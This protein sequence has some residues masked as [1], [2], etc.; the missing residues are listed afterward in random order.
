MPSAGHEQSAEAQLAKRR[1]NDPGSDGVQLT[2]ET[3][4][5]MLP[6]IVDATGQ[7]DDEQDP[8]ETANTNS[9][10]AQR[11]TQRLAAW[12]HACGAALAEKLHGH[13]GL[14]EHDGAAEFTQDPDWE[15]HQ[16]CE[17]NTRLD[18]VTRGLVSEA[19]GD[20][21]EV[22][23][24][25]AWATRVL[26]NK[27]GLLARIEGLYA[28]K[29]GRGLYEDGVD[30][31]VL[32]DALARA[33]PLDN[34]YAG[35]RRNQWQGETKARDQKGKYQ[36]RPLFASTW[37]RLRRGGAFAKALVELAR[38]VPLTT[39]LA[40][41]LRVHSDFVAMVL[42]RDLAVLLPSLVTQADVDSVVVIGGGALSTFEACAAAAGK[43]KKERLAELHARLSEL[44][45]PALLQA[46]VRGSRKFVRSTLQD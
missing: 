43:C 21:D 26:L 34:A 11:S 38:G 24:Q 36:Q 37:A 3:L 40:Q 13:G 20:P 30:D 22:R 46:V 28:A 15:T 9:D 19:C 25:K 4:P 32:C 42:A 5:Q 10:Q 39:V 31:Q 29:A 6:D 27:R 16:R 17:I 18:G 33:G 45:D 12:I 8:R 44:L 1:R 14:T 2:P 23:L 41:T 7:Q 35:M